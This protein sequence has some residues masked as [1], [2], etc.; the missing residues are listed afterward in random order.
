MKTLL[1]KAGLKEQPIV[2]L[3]TDIQLN[4]NTTF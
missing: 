4:V 1:L 2:F 3:T